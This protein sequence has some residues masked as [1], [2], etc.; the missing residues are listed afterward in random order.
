MDI[1][2]W[3]GQNT[4]TMDTEI[5]QTVFVHTDIYCDTDSLNKYIPRRFAGII[6]K[7]YIYVFK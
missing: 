4:A 1:H 6:S 2:T 5:L 3:M 7:Y